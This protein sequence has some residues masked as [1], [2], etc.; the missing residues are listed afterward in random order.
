M[1]GGLLDF[2]LVMILFNLVGGSPQGYLVVLAYFAGMWAW[3]STTVGGVVLGL[4]VVRL[5]GQPLSFPVAL[6]R[7]LSAAFSIVVLFLGFLWIAWDPGKEGWHDKITG[8]AVI[9]LPR[10][11]PLV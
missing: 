3:K 1:A 11:T 6:V 5:D 2:V 10:V 9:K 8:T 4:K 7:A